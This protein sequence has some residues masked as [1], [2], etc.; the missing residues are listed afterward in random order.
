MTSHPLAGRKR[1]A[2]ATD[3]TKFWL[4]P[5]QKSAKALTG[6]PPVRQDLSMHHSWP[7]EKAMVGFTI[8]LK[9]RN[10]LPVIVESVASPEQGL[11]RIRLHLQCRLEKKGQTKANH[12]VRVFI[13]FCSWAGRKS[14]IFHT[15]HMLSSEH[16]APFN[17]PY[18][19]TLIFYQILST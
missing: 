19:T 18:S 8:G 12:T 7:V 3:E 11:P 4:R 13:N 15:N 5:L 2:C 1:I 14:Q 9:F 17:F 10:A 16:W 6:L